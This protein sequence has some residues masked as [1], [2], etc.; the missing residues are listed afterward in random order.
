[1]ARVIIVSPHEADR[2]ALRDALVR[3]TER[4][5]LSCP[6]IVGIESIDELRERL[7]RSPAGSYRAALWC[8]R[9]GIPALTPG[10]V[11]EL[12][13]GHPDLQIVVVSSGND[14]AL[15]TYGL[16]ITFLPV[17][18]EWEVL[19][20]ALWAALAPSGWDRQPHLAVTSPG[21]VDN[22]AFSDIQFIESSKRGPVIHL[23]GR[24]TVTAR[25]TLKGLYESLNQM[26]EQL[27]GQV[28]D[29]TTQVPAGWWPY[30]MVGSSF[31]VNLDNVMAFGKG[32]LVLSD[33][34]TII[35]PQRRRKELEAALAAYRGHA[36]D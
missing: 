22:V 24:Q 11:A 27:E 6:E 12:R 10:K 28:S 35:V 36:Q 31:I 32:V 34:E 5:G 9:N 21:R 3:C 14:A 26:R 13:R 29:P 8:T 20:Q 1:M 17:P 19:E 2:S 30:V 23:P 4:L 7:A 18:I 33:G 16:G 25:G 15:A